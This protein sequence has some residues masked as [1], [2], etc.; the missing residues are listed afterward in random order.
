MNFERNCQYKHENRFPREVD[1]IKSN[2]RSSIFCCIMFI[3][4][5]LVGIKRIEFKLIYSRI[6]AEQFRLKF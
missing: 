5:V 2:S 6:Q 3:G 4:H 1:Q